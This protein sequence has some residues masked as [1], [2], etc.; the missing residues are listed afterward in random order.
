MEKNKAVKRW[1]E[2]SDET[3]E[4]M[5]KWREQHP[6]ASL[7]EIEK[8]L[9]ERIVKLRAKILEEAAQLSEMQKW[10]E[11]ENIAVCPDCKQAL[12]FRGKGKRELQTQGGHSIQLEREYGICP[13]CGQGFFPPG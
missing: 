8:A 3:M 1:Q 12:E 11:S 5:G 9:D 7:R 6:K 4:G 10:T 13:K 2:L